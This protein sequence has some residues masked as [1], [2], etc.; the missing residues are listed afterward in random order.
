MDRLIDD[1]NAEYGKKSPKHARTLLE[2]KERHFDRKL[3]FWDSRNQEPVH[4]ME[5][6]GKVTSLNMSSDGVHVLCST[7]DDTL[8]LMDVRKYQTV[9]IYSAPDGNIFV[10]NIQSTKLEKVLHKGGH[11]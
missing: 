5:M 1:D 11:E 2:M 6:A 7:R 3:R 4:T 9:H 8:S 10:W